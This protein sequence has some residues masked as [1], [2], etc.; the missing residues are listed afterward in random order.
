VADRPAQRSMVVRKGSFDHHERRRCAALA[1][2]AERDDVSLT[3]LDALAFVGRERPEAPPCGTGVTSLWSGSV[4][5]PM[6]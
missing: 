5:V 2:V 3:G 6:T 1:P 4:S